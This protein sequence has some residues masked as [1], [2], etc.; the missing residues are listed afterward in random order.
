MVMIFS[1]EKS[2]IET[3]PTPIDLEMKDS[4]AKAYDRV[5]KKVC[6]SDEVTY[7][8][9]MRKALVKITCP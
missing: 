8:S 6:Y 9:T 2:N 7:P 1:T 4:P 3:K 5:K